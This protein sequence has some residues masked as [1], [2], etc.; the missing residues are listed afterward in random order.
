MLTLL[1]AL[2]CMQL[3]SFA[4]AEAQ[5]KI[6]W[7]TNYEEAISQSKATSKPVVL[8]FTG[9][10]WCGWCNKLDE[11]VLETSEFA[12]AVGD[13]F[14]FVKLDFPP[15]NALSQQLIAQNKQLQ[16]KYDVRAFPTVIII[17]SQQQQIG[18]TGYRA[19]GPKPYAQHLLQMLNDYSS[20]RGKLSTLDKLSGDDLKELFDQANTLGLYSDVESIT[21]AGLKSDE[22]QFFLTERY[23][24][25]VIDGKI[26]TPEAAALREKLLK[27]DPENE[28]G[29][30]YQVAIIDFEST[31][32]DAGKDNFSPEKAVAPLISYI[33]QFPS[34]KTNLWRLQMIIAQVYFDK[35]KLTEAL[36][37][38]ELAYDAA[39][40]N[41]QA[42]I[43]AV[44]K[45]IKS[46]VLTPQ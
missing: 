16:Q 11:E 26:N 1:F 35:N 21:K 28:N 5:T 36:K 31:C 18:K 3:F 30:H 43:A 44:I 32:E 37:H 41:A 27:S 15:N 13:K 23:R 25:L 42:E 40:S 45:T 17:D 9:S 33:N 34:D 12:Q 2:L 22:E 29:I 7:T 19:G 38:A 10:A 20:Y 6:N 24:A 8:F 4:K 14:I 46:Q 39:P